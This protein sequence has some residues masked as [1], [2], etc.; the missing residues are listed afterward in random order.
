MQNA[1]ANCVMYVGRRVGRDNLPTALLILCACAAIAVGVACRGL[2]LGLGARRRKRYA[3]Q[4]ARRMWV[5]TSR[6]KSRQVG[7]HQ[8]DPRPVGPR[9]VGQVATRSVNAR[10]VHSHNANTRAGPQ[11][12]LGGSQG[13]VPGGDPQASIGSAGTTGAPGAAGATAGAPVVVVGGG[14]AG[15]AAAFE[16]ASAGRAVVLLERDD[17]VGGNI[18]SVEIDGVGVDVGVVQL[19]EWYWCVLDVARR[20]GV[21]DRIVHSEPYEVYLHLNSAAVPG[22]VEQLPNVYE[23]MKGSLAVPLREMPRLALLEKKLLDKM[24]PADDLSFYRPRPSPAVPASES[25][26]RLLHTVP[27]H[28]ARANTWNEA[29]LY[30]PLAERPAFALLG[31]ATQSEAELSM[32]GHTALLADAIADRIVQLGG[33]ILTGATVASV[34]TR[35]NTLTYYRAARPDYDQ[36]KSRDLDGTSAPQEL[37]YS[38]L[39]L[40]GPPDAV[41]FDR[42]PLKLRRV[43]RVEVGS[44]VPAFRYTQALVLVVELDK[45]LEVNGTTEWD[46]CFEVPDPSLAVQIASVTNAGPRGLPNHVLLYIDVRFDV[47]VSQWR[48]ETLNAHP[49]ELVAA[50]ERV[51]A[52]RVNGPRLMRVRHTQWFDAAMPALNYAAYREVDKQQGQRGIWYAG[53]WVIGHPSL[54][55]AC[56][57]GQRVAYKIIG[58]RE[59][60]QFEAY[61]QDLDAR[62]I[63][64]KVGEA[65]SKY[66]RIL[67][68]V[69]VGLLA[70]V[71]L[72]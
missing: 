11:G 61:V 2:A 71:L 67:G 10:S 62:R 48:T 72:L 27:D 46:A 60:Q 64:L 49:N 70:L 39:I 16:L 6:L 18:K 19:W 68:F 44:N 30:P 38:S 32:R 28:A 7:A 53:Q 54:E 4:H 34:D 43:G 51:D 56:Y 15:L 57:S 40:A 66:Q 23:K 42:P 52:I 41:E 37:A 55:L 29:Y 35:R 3:Q 31:V 33:T 14:M 36:D 22:S 50:M 9:P 20:V 26:A 1:Y 5:Q 21:S 25:V 63:R 47:D 8:A 69:S 17:R 65:K 13:G 58:N 12:P 59:S 45:A 24:E